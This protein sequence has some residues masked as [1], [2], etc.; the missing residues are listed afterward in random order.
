M[1]GILYFVQKEFRQVFRD[2]AMLRIIFVVPLLQLFVFAYATNTDLRRVR[3]A[4]LDED[5]SGASR[6]LADAFPATQE[7]V[8]GPRARDVRE[9]ES[10][11]RRGAADLALHIPRDYERDLLLGRVPAVGLTVDGTNSSLAGRATGYAT[12]IVRREAARWRAEA[13]PA[14]GGRVPIEAVTRFFYNPELE[15][16]YYMVPAILVLLVTVISALLTGMSV[17]RE[18][19]IGTLEQ[20]QVSPLKPAQIIAGKTIPY[21]VIAFFE[22][23]LAT[24]IA[25]FAFRLPLAGS[26]PVFALGAAVYLLV[27]LGIGLLASTVSSTQQQAMFAV[28][29]FL[30]FGI[31]MSG[32][33][34]PID[35]MP[36]WA[37]ELTR[38]NP[39]RYM[40]NIVRGV[41]LKGAGFADL[42]QDLAVLAGLG[43][44]VFSAAVLRFRKRSG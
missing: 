44:T 18:K 4:V 35:N 22:L 42:R 23:A 10:F 32:F 9:L 12:T 2:R 21:A 11:L 28:W 38:V 43:L 34:Y 26:L 37:R 20:L 29:F 8:P 27:T 15:S 33:F 36:A 13:S 5:R 40:M 17:V 16:R 3:V 25:V 19:E 41:F 39:L 31:L 6:R 24:T 30:V 14:A 7:F 1:R